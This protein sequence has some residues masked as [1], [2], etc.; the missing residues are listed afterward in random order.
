MSET[1]EQLVAGKNVAIIGVGNIGSQQV[2]HQ[3]RDPAVRHLT[4]VDPDFCSAENHSQEYLPE[5]IGKK[6]AIVSARRARRIR[7]HGDLQVDAIVARVEDVPWG[8]LRAD[9]IL[10][11]VDSRLAR[12][13][14]NRIA[15]RLNIPWIDAGIRSQGS[16]VRIEVHLPGAATPCIECSWNRSDFELMADATYTCDGRLNQPAPTRSPSSLGGLAAALQAIECRKILTEA[17]DQSLAGKQLIIE[18]D[19]HHHYVNLL[20]RNPSCRFDHQIWTIAKAPQSVRTMGDLM[21]HGRMLFGGKYPAD[22]SAECKNWVTRLVCRNCRQQA[23]ALRLQGRLGR[24]WGLCVRCGGE[25][26]PIGFHLCPRLEFAS[27]GNRLLARPLRNYGLRACD[28]MTL[29]N[30]HDVRHIELDLSPETGGN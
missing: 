5:D 9:V 10:A 12:A 17:A 28:V 14:I 1:G 13:A 24:M 7:H 19:F 25:M 30:E 2:T 27:L 15:W 26:Q 23:R 21:D 4:L 22:V 29:T 16:L 20:R 6:K 8:R 3:A 18:A 11:C